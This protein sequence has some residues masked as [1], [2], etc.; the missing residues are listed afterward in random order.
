MRMFIFI[1]IGL[2]GVT[3][4]ISLV[5]MFLGCGMGCIANGDYICAAFSF[6]MSGFFVGLTNYIVNDYHGE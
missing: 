5:L 1:L 4:A 3:A 2:A 6:L